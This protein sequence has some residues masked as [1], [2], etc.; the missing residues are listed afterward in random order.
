MNMHKKER[1]QTLL[2]W[3]SY[4]S[5]FESI[6]VMSFIVKTCPERRRIMM[7]ANKEMFLKKELYVWVH[8]LFQ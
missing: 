8:T 3:L 2:V 7:A 4:N 1:R 5:A 6:G